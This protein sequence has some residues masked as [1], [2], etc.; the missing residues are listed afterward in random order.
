MGEST[1]GFSSIATSPES[2]L[3]SATTG[4]TQLARNGS[5]RKANNNAPMRKL[6][7]NVQL[8]LDEIR[9]DLCSTNWETRSAGLARF[10]EMCTTSAKAVASDTNVCS[11]L[12]LSNN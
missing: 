6:P 3:S 9:S 4:T 11:V 5:I 10:K 1:I 8:D 2:T 12:Y 7:D